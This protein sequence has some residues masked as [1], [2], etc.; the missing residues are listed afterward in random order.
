MQEKSVWLVA[1]CALPFVLSTT[2]ARSDTVGWWPL[3]FEDGVRTTVETVFPSEVGNLVARPL[4]M[5][6]ATIIA[7]SD[8]CPQGT[9]AFPAGWGVWNPQTGV[10][11]SGALGL[12]FHKTTSSNPSGVLR[13]ANVDGELNLQTF[14]FEAFVRKQA[15]LKDQGQWNCIAVI[16]GKLRTSSGETV[17]NYDSWAVRITGASQMQVRFTKPGAMEV[18]ATN[19]GSYNQTMTVS[20][21]TIYDGKWHHIALVVSAAD[22]KAHAYYDYEYKTSISLPDGLSYGTE[23]LYLGGTPQTAGCYGG[24][25]AHVR[26][27]DRVLQ[28]TE[29]LQLSN[30]N[31]STDVVLHADFETPEGLS[32]KDSMALNRGVGASVLLVQ[33]GGYPMVDS[34]TVPTVRTYS[35]V[36]DQQGVANGAALRNLPQSD[37]KKTYATFQPSGDDFTNKSFTVECYYRTEQAKQY[38]PLVRRRGGSNVQFNLGFGGTAGK[39]SATVLEYYAGT[40]KDGAKT[41]V[42]T[43]ATNDGNWHHAALVVDAELKTVSLFRDSVKVGEVTYNGVLVAG[44]TP[45]CLAGVDNG[46]SFDGLIDDVRITMKALAPESFMSAICVDTSARTVAWVGFEDG[47]LVARESD[48][49]LT[50][51]TA[52]AAI[53]GGAAP[54]IVS[55]DQKGKLTDRAYNILRK[56]NESALSFTKSVVKY[57]RNPYLA[58]LRNFTVE[59]FLKSGPQTMY[60]GIMR[61]NSTPDGTLPAWAF[62]FGDEKGTVDTLRIRCATRNGS[63][64]HKAA[65]NDNTGIVIGDNRWH[66]IAATFEET[67]R[68]DGG[69]WTTV[70]IYK[71]FSEEPSWEKTVPDSINY[72]WAVGDVWLG[73]SSSTETAFTGLMDEIRISNGV[74]EPSEF[75]RYGKR[76]MMIRFR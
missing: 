15:N 68:T 67:P 46:N 26:L 57:S 56:S 16:P 20:T 63:E 43:V 52:D 35:S 50:V 58:L 4:S 53:S 30:L 44:T 48:G 65:I 1:L 33:S 31:E 29:F 61:A 71:D 19:V 12:Y 38:I 17:L 10:R 7:G 27:S 25:L 18:D 70:K 75:M 28:T 76:G 45:V 36:L 72:G 3:A 6:G 39:L 69:V 23:D 13:I 49:A 51:A 22:K 2:V 55:T 34:Q 9:A 21:P 14:T 60:T 66:H 54:T 47:S 73:A 32:F 64:T 11:K 40:G 41:V 24:S 62:S 42:D 5:Q 37:D 8:F 74:L 59:F